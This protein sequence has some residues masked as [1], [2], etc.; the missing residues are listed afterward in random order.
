MDATVTL[1]DVAARA[2][3]SVG[4]ASRVL[5]GHSATSPA[6]RERVR[7]AA[8]ELGYRVNARAQALRSARSHAVGLLVSDVRNPFFADIA[9]GAEQTALASS[10]VTLLAN[11]TGRKPPGHRA[12]QHRLPALR[13]PRLRLGLAAA[14]PGQRPADRGRSGDPAGVVTASLLATATTVLS[15]ALTDRVG[16]RTVYLVACVLAAVFGFPM[17]LMANT[18]APVL[19]V[20]IF[21][22]GIGVIH[23]ALTGTQAAWFAELFTTATRTSGASLGYQTAASVAGFAPFLAVLLAESFGWAGPAGLYVCIALVGLLGVLSTRETWSPERRA[24]LPAGQ[25][26][27]AAD[28]E[29]HPSR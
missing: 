6:A 2:G 5:S 21:L 14:L 13:H 17:Y 8:T 19:I 12:R 16:R 11:A 10:Y 29:R 20:L 4:T 28:R 15:G 7:A 23:A 9:H 3:V 27:R 25:P 22:I 1:K 18:G 24:V 26:R